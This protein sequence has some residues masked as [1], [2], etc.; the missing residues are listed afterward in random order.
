MTR[1]E[2][3]EES[4]PDETGRRDFLS[5]LAAI[6][7]GGIVTLPP[8]VIGVVAALDPLRRGGGDS[9]HVMVTRL[10]A[11]PDSGVPRR[12]SITST[13]VDA[14]TTHQSTP[15]GAVY[16]RRD[17]DGVTALNTVCPHAGCF[18]GIKSDESG[19]AC[20][21][22]GSSFAIDGA[23]DDPNS[24]S[25]RAMDALDVEIRNG[26]EVWVRFQNFLPGREEKTP[27]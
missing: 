26:D 27:V 18:V 9:G 7:V 5:S 17:G 22:H 20:P 10:A 8:L 25:P 12:F 4:H 21:C 11:L 23:V 16:L 13:R 6:F 19:F 14:W 3:L 2:P 15:I 24:P 1:P